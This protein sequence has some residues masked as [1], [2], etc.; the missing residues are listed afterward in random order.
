MG[1]ISVNKIVKKSGDGREY[2]NEVVNVMSPILSHAVHTSM[3]KRKNTVKLRQ[4]RKG[5][6]KK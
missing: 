1:I 2:Q 5:N 6:N 3:S 4:L